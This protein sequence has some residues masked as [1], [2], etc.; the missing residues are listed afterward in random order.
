VIFRRDVFKVEESMKFS[1]TNPFGV[2]NTFN[3][4]AT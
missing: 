4:G 3:L 2:R 1:T